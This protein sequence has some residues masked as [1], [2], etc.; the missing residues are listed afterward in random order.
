MSNYPKPKRFNYL[1]FLIAVGIVLAIIIGVVVYKQKKPINNSPSPSQ[2][3]PSPPNPPSPSSP[4][5]PP[6][7]SPHPD[8]PDT[9][10]SEQGQKLKSEAEKEAKK[11]GVATS[12][13]SKVSQFDEL[14]KQAQ[15]K[16]APV[17]PEEL[18]EREKVIRDMR[19]LADNPTEAAKRVG[20]PEKAEEYQDT[21]PP[22]IFVEILFADAIN[23]LKASNFPQIYL[24]LSETEAKKFE[25][26]LV[27]K[28]FAVNEK[29]VTAL[30][31]FLTI[32][33]GGT[34]TFETDVA[35]WLINHSKLLIEGWLIDYLSHQQAKYFQKTYVPFELEFDN[36]G[37]RQYSNPA[38]HVILYI[39]FYHSFNL[40]Q[41]KSIDY[42][43]PN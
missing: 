6:N 36:L 16:C 43:K 3:S 7:P 26:E 38:A 24:Q 5:S 29:I 2:D 12:K 1:P 22:N 4:P 31:N 20:K 15:E 34:T 19:S 30:G 11:R 8:V 41:E 9:P 33:A 32:G 13:F 35:A 27:S 28:I 17:F 21:S 10:L 40:N 37:G 18:L 14:L 42:S 25:V 23:K 39:L